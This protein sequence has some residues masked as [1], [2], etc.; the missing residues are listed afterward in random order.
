MKYEYLHMAKANKVKINGGY[1]SQ[2]GSNF[3]I[4]NN[5]WLLI[6]TKAPKF[7]QKVKKNGVKLGKIQKNHFFRDIVTPK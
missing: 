3:N 2:W 4:Q 1:K 7:I 6:C 5:N